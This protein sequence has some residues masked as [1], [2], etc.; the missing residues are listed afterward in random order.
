MDINNF[1][2]ETLSISEAVLSASKENP[3]K[4]ALN[5]MGIN[6]S[7]KKLMKKTEALAFAF[8]SL[9]LRKGDAALIFL[10]NI[11]QAVYA[12]YA[13]NRIGAVSAFASPLSA[14]AEIETYINKTK[15]KLVVALDTLCDKIKN[16]FAK[17][18]DVKLVIT[19]ALD[20]LLPLNFRKKSDI[21]YWQNLYKIK[22]KG[23]IYL[24][25]QKSSD[26][27]VILFSGGT[28]GPPKAVELTNLNLNALAEGTKQACG[29]DVKGVSML[30]VLPV[31]HGFGLGICIHTTLYFSGECIL[32][33]RFDS[34]KTGRIIKRQKPQY[35]AAVPAMLTPLINSKTLAKADLSRLKGVFSGGD[36]LKSELEDDFN[37][38]LLKHNSQAK[39]R[40][41]Y[42]L[43][44]CVAASCLM[45]LN[46]YKKESIGKPYP[47]TL[48]KIVRQNTTEEA[49]ENSEGEI[50]ISGKTVMKG[51][52]YDEAETK[53]VLKIHTD[54]KR[55]LHTGDMGYMDSEGFVYFTGRLK[56]MIISNGCNIYP[57]ELEKALL[58]H[59]CVK[60]CCAVG[61]KDPQRAQCAVMFAVINPKS[62]V[63]ENELTEHLRKHISKQSMPGRI[64]PIDKIPKTPLGKTAYQKLVTMAETL[65]K[66]EN[67]AE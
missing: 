34:I 48:Y 45:P 56:R 46:E 44:E 67:T 15:P 4:T 55:W 59:N 52:L 32:V 35:I 47:H 61:V 7:C 10:P 25:P 54:G 24:S 50:C 37:N 5:F 6:I 51:Y 21:I 29:T 57:S 38:F 18:G 41:G 27:A 58:K 11:P 63:K 31:F 1:S 26:T 14:E 60:E 65:I 30:S 62:K 22:Q 39:I 8:Y 19:S 40:R 33:P 2:R 3:G 17:T 64:Y 42:G 12:L 23:N 16:V 53:N 66:A 43:T 36:S 20:E 49:L 13:L 9:G 28:T